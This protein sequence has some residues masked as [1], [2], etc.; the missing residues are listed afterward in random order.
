LRRFATG[1]LLHAGRFPLAFAL[2]PSESETKV[3]RYTHLSART[4]EAVVRRGGRVV[5]A[6]AAYADERSSAMISWE[7]LQLSQVAFAMRVVA[8]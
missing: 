2:S 6:S 7:N 3:F 5:I 8:N 1:T 4:S